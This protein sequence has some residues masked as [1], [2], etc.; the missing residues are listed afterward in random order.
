[1]AALEIRAYEPAHAA[2]Y[3]R[4]PLRVARAIRRAYAVE[5]HGD[6]PDKLYGHR[7]PDVRRAV[8]PVLHGP[9]HHGQTAALDRQ[10]V[11]RVQ[12]LRLHDQRGV[13]RVDRRYRHHRG[14]PALAAVAGAVAAA[15]AVEVAA[16]NLE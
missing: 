11:L 10:P 4:A 15:E 16:D 5:R 9:P 7:P 6:L 13:V 14:R 3:V 8:A 1:H 12:A 2:R